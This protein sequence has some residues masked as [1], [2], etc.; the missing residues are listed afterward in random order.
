[1][2][3]FLAVLVLAAGCGRTKQL[4]RQNQEQARAIADLNEELARLKEELRASGAPSAYPGAGS[5]SVKSV[6][7]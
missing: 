3:F 4:E 2:V 7:K 5:K 1:M 6:I